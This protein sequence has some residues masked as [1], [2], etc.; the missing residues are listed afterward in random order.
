MKLHLQNQWK[1]LNKD[2]FWFILFDFGYDE[3]LYCELYR[4]YLIVFNIEL[5][6]TFKPKKVSKK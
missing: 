3:T 6:L 5:E 2:D 4:V 1:L